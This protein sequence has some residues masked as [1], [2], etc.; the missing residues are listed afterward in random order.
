[1]YDYIKTSHEFIPIL[2]LKLNHV[3]INTIT[4][5]D[6]FRYLVAPTVK[7]KTGMGKVMGY[8]L[9]NPKQTR[10][11][12]KLQNRKRD[13]H[14]AIRHERETRL[15]SREK[16]YARF[17]HCKGPDARRSRSG[18]LTPNVLLLAYQLEIY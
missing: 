13:R 7:D 8:V 6:L 5:T 18:K 9:V 2:E 12:N 16:R 1:M 15:S 17:L 4:S 3:W 11:T 10:Y 14:R